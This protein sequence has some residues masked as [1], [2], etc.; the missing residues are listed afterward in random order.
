MRRAPG[1]IVAVLAVAALS[2]AGCARQDASVPDEAIVRAR[3]AIAPFKSQLMEA[4]T[5]ALRDGGPENA[6]LVCRVQAPA[7]AAA[8]GGEGISIGR[9]SHRLRNPANAPEEWMKPFLLAYQADPADTTSRAVRL[10]AGTVGY[11][12]PIHAKPLCLTCH[13]TELSPA[14]TDALASLYPDDEAT[15]FAMDDFR[16]MFW[17]KVAVAGEAP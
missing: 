12:E 5:T 1:S 6:L 15:G 9:T 2:P 7:I 10:D 3:A 17:A 4:L 13:G 8:A 14:V 16:G 11:V